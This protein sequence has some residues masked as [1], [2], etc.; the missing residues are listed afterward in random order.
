VA[1]EYKTLLYEKDGEVPGILYITL[2]RP[3]K[4]NAISICPDQV[5]GEIQD[6]IRRANDDDEVKVVIFRGRGTSFSA[7]FDLSMVY[8]VYGGRPGFR[9]HQATRL[10]IDDEQLMGMPRAVLG[11]HKVTMAQVH[12]WCIEAGMYIVESCDIAIAAK[13]ALFCHRGQRLAFGGMPYIPLEVLSGHTKKITEL[14]ITGRTINGEEAEQAGIVTKAVP[15]EDLEQEVR[16]LAEAICH[17]PMDAIVMGK[18]CRR[19]VYEQVGL[20]AV[21]PLVTYHTLG[22]NITYRPEERGT[23][24]I[25]DREELGAREAFHKLHV[26]FEAALNRTK[27]FKSLEP[28]EGL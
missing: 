1:S 12:G 10:R 25:R 18:M 20:T 4:R 23:V 13:D 22:T 21:L 9:P 11:C 3:E 16:L 15:P 28:G 19:M 2:N 26:D 24:F 8:R 14:L 5:T 27:Y 17:L 6:A 7:G